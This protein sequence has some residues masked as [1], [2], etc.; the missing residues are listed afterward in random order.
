MWH[1]RS[2]CCQR[3]AH[4]QYADGWTG[5]SRRR[6]PGQAPWRRALKHERQYTGLPWVGRKGRVADIL[7]S[8]QTA[9]YGARLDG[10]GRAARAVG[11]ARAIRER[12]PLIRVRTQVN[13]RGRTRREGER[14]RSVLV[15][16]LGAPIKRACSIIAQRDGNRNPGRHSQVSRRYAVGDRLAHVGGSK[17]RIEAEFETVLPPM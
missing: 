5:P 6:P 7:Q 3:L 13:Q 14:G 9:W 4:L 8:S 2:V 11:Y 1:R 12:T 17:R 15:S 16:N 10:R